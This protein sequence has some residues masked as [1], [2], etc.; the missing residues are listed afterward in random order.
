M[1]S[2]KRSFAASYAP[3]GQRA[4][5]AT[6]AASHD[7]RPAPVESAWQRWEM[8]SLGAPSRRPSPT[9]RTPHDAKTA[10]PPRTPPGPTLEDKLLARLRVDARAMGE[11]EGR[12]QG[13]TQG[14]AEGLEAGRTEGRAEGMALATAH[15]EQL[16]TLA[17]SLPAALASAERELSSSLISLALDV[18]R[19]VIHHSLEAEPAWIVPLVQQMLNTK[20]ALQGEPR[21]LL[22]TDDVALVRSSL[23]SALQEAG[24]QVRVDD[25]ISRGGCRVQCAGSEIDA[26]LETRWERV[27]AALGG[28]T[29]AIHG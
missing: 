14:H 16:R 12:R 6:V 20:P 15:A 11:A 28:D 19:Q 8:Q 22:H 23:G 3:L 1:T 2:S 29:G 17:Q 21:L 24:W 27:T 18:A 9:A 7:E 13:W 10:A 5:A 26:T 25:S 4:A